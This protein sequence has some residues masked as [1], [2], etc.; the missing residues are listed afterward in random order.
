MKRLAIG[1]IGALALG[2]CAG[3]H[4]KKPSVCDG[5]HRRP[6]NLYGTVLPT[7]P[8]PLPAS[9]GGGR[10]MVVPGPTGRPGELP[11]PPPAPAPMSTP[12]PDG[13]AA[14][15]AANTGAAAPQ[16]PRTS[17]RDLA[18]SYRSC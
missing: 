5:K 6:A 13:S 14:P 15:S 4:V 9:Q 7:L 8:L 10:S 3:A 16:A 1:L 18:L 11:P 2:G 17:Q 12:T